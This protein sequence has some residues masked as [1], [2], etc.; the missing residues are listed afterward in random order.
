[1]ATTDPEPSRLFAFNIP[2]D[3]TPAVAK[4]I[5]DNFTALARL[6]YTTDE[7][8]PE[9]PQNGMPRINAVDPNNIK[10]QVWIDG[11]WKTIASFLQ[12]GNGTPSKQVVEFSVGANPWVI[13]HN[14]GSFPQAQA[15]NV[16]GFVFR[17]VPEAVVPGVN[18]C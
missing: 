13:D 12:L 6:N 9:N 10:L 3:D 18:E 8:Y 5:R 7:D 1:M 17:V 11:A 4:E 16:N 2:A 15:F 14:I